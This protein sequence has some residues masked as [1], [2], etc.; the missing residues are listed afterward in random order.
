MEQDEN[1]HLHK[2]ERSAYARALRVALEQNTASLRDI[3]SIY[4]FGRGFRC[5]DRESANPDIFDRQDTVPR[6]QPYALMYMLGALALQVSLSRKAAVDERKRTEDQFEM[7]EDISGQPTNKK[8]KDAME[9]WIENIPKIRTIGLDYC[10]CCFRFLKQGVEKV[11]KRHY[12]YENYHW[13]LFLRDRELK[14]NPWATEYPFVHDFG[15][16]MLIMCYDAQDPVY[17]VV[18]DLCQQ[19]GMPGAFLDGLNISGP[20]HKPNE[21]NPTSESFDQSYRSR[22]NGSIVYDSTSHTGQDYDY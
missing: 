8:P 18:A 13:S 12:Q 11:I 15:P 22:K 20:N 17:E 19:G 16:H 10:D 3:T 2:W 21:R 14:F 4:C 9:K 6:E 1:P 7:N 5:F